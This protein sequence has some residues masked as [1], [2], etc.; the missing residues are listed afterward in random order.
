MFISLN[1]YDNVSNMFGNEYRI[2]S[3]AI[4]I[5]NNEI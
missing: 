3:W 5:Q 2:F 1:F 4:V